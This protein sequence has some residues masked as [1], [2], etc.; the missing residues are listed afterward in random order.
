MK[1]ALIIGAGPAGI[2]ASLYLARNNNIDVTIVSN[3]QSALSRAHLIENYFGFAEPVSGKQLLENGRKNAERLG[4]HFLDT[5]LIELQFTPELKFSAA[6]S[7]EKEEQVFDSVLIATGAS[8]KDPAISG[9]DRFKGRGISYCAVCDA[10]FYRNKAA[11]VIGSGEY[12]V[13]EASTLSNSCSSVTIL[14]NGE[15]LSAKAP[16]GINVITAKIREL[17]GETTL[18]SVIFEDDSRL[19]ISGLFIAIGTAGSSDIARKLGAPLDGSNIIVDKNMATAVPG[20]FA[21]GDCTGGLMQIAKAVSDG[22]IAGLG[23][24][25]FLSVSG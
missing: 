5:E 6:F 19:E 3:G 18:D 7:G 4:A 24:I 15:E 22:A 1:K 10:F 12:A 21:A 2:S 17:S 16:E 14:T 11:A 25:K 9:M 8:R 20:L 13:H 23:M